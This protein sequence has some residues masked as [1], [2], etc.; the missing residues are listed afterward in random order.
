MVIS[1]NTLWLM[2]HVEYLLRTTLRN[3]MACLNDLTKRFSSA[4]EP[5]STLISELPK[6]LWGEA[7]NH[8]IWLKNQTA[9]PNGKTP[10]K[11]WYG[12]KPH[13]ARLR[14]WGS[15]VWVHDNCRSKL[16]GRSKI[17]HWVGFDEAS[18]AHYIHW[19][20]KCAVTEC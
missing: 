10:Y 16:D 19:P 5:F 18:D 8:A 1:V 20:D 7:I 6:F 15:T 13:L 4:P 17:G 3:I 2:E 14:E 11:M 9:L 12:K